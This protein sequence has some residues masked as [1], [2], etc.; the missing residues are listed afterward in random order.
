MLDP[1]PCKKNSN[2]KFIDSKP[3]LWLRLES[4][5]NY[6]SVI[7]MKN[8]EMITMAAN[9]AAS[10]LLGVLACSSC[11]VASSQSINTSSYQSTYPSINL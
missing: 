4:K 11:Q 8:L 3:K 6:K 1:E 9:A 5:Q 2:Y 10:V 7:L